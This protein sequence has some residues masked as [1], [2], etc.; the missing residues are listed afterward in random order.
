MH[1]FFHAKM[2]PVGFEPHALTKVSELKSDAIDPSG[3]V[4]VRKN[5]VYNINVF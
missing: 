1:I 2:I 3:K 4:P 5:K